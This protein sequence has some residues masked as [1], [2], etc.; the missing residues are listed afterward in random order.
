MEQHIFFCAD[1]KYL[2]FTA[3]TMTS[4]L[5]NATPDSRQ[6]FHL[7]S[8]DINEEDIAVLRT[9]NSLKEC[10]VELHTIRAEDFSAWQKMDFGYISL[11]CL[12][13]FKI[14]D[15][16]PQGVEK[17]LYLDGD[18][19]V[20]G[21][22]DDL[23]AENLDGYA[24][25][26]VEEKGAFQTQNLHLKGGRYFNSGMLL[27]NVKALAQ[28]DILA[29]ALAYYRENHE[30]IVSHDQDILNGMWDEKV[31][32]LAQKYNVPSFVKHFANP[33]VIHYTG[34]VK[35]PWHAY[36][37]HPQK[38]VWLKYA[39]MSP[40]KKSVWQLGFFLLKRLL[41]EI[42]YFAK[43]PTHRRYYVVSIL[44]MNF[45]IGKKDDKSRI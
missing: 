7:I 20:T 3:V 25:G 5:A 26:A 15:F 39:Q 17:V 13:R 11:G 44:S 36:C 16:V 6:V 27:L 18:M 42:F 34:F 32:F 2:P 21:P 22:L 4:V 29:E 14:L 45:G 24:A 19:I 10:A 23:F 8:A 9:L 37:R 31:K 35:K 12:Y 38:N 1:R 30:H 28:H 43:E 40:Y 41:T 33:L